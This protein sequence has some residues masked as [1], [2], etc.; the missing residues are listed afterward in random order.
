MERW[1]RI[2]DHLLEEAI[3]DGDIFEPARRRQKP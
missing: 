2:V 3:G 1:A